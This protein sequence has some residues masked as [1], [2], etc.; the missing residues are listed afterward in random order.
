MRGRKKGLG[1][2]CH[3]NRDGHY[4]RVGNVHCLIV[5]G[6]FEISTPGGLKDDSLIDRILEIAVLITLVFIFAGVVLGIVGLFQRK[7][8]K[9]FSVVGLILNGLIILIIAA[10][11]IIGSFEDA[12]SK[13]Q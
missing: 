13:I 10:L 6:Y 12:S 4:G 1:T 3:F 11:I 2:R 8:K 7:R 5:V 9:L